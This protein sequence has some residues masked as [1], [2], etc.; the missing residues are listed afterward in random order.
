[1]KKKAIA[2]QGR[3]RIILDSSSLHHD[4]T[5]KPSEDQFEK[6]FMD[7]AQGNSAIK[8]GQFGRYSHD[9][10]FIIYKN[11]SPLKV[12]LGS[13][14]FS[15]TG[16]YVNSNHIVIFNDITV[17]K[18]YS[19]VFEESWNDNITMA[20][21]HSSFATQEFSFSSVGVPKT[22]ITFKIVHK[23]VTNH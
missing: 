13:T 11:N 10:I 2:A 18:T 1:M 8:R 12:L 15:V 21:S 19:A 7:K 23:F 16:M 4:S 6:L 14:N 9:K 5:G 3:I 17:A 20:F 22:D